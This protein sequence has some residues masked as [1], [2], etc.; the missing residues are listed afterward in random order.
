M[1]KDPDYSAGA[2]AVGLYA[3]HDKKFFEALLKD[4]AK[5]L[6]EL[7][8]SGT[9]N[10]SAEDRRTVVRLIEEANHRDWSPMEEWD[11]WK[12][13]GIWGGGWPFGWPQDR[14]L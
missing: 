7:A 9:L 2:F 10:I 8:D 3:L 6:Q 11:H 1:G 14:R 13:T 4:P 5:A 12:R